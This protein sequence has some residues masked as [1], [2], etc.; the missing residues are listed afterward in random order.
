MT[1]GNGQDAR[2][3]LLDKLA[4]ARPGLEAADVRAE[5]D[6]WLDEHPDDEEVRRAL[7][8]IGSSGEDPTEGDLE[9]GSP[10]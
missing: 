7:G 2:Q 3:E 4:E 1:E 9:E 6:R 10:S 5:A 8:K